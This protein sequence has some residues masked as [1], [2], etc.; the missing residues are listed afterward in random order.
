[1]SDYLRELDDVICGPSWGLTW[2]GVILR[3]GMGCMGLL[4]VIV[5]S[6]TCLMIAA[7]QYGA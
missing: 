4:A 6:I 1:M 5:V 2:K 7:M 3:L